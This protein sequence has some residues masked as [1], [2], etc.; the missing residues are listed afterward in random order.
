[1]IKSQFKSQILRGRDF[2]KEVI[3]DKLLRCMFESPWLAEETKTLS[4]MENQTD[5][6]C[7]CCHCS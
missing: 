5:D 2:I 4:G 1:M 3:S 6:E 7:C